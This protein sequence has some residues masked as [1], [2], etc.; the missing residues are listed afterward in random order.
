VFVGRPS[1]EQTNM[2]P[3][4]CVQ[5][6]CAGMAGMFTARIDIRFHKNFIVV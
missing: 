5:S 3:V 6:I 2:D 4:T 1:L